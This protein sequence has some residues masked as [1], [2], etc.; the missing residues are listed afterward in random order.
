MNVVLLESSDEVARFADACGGPRVAT[1][2]VVVALSPQAQVELRRRGLTFADT[3]PYFDNDSHRRIL[4]T[5]E[6]WLAT[7]ER[8]L[9]LED[10]SGARVSYETEFQFYGRFFINYFL[11]AMEI[12]KSAVDR[13]GA[14]TITVCAER[15]GAGRHY[16]LRAADRPLASIAGRFA[17]ARGIACV[18]LDAPV[19]PRARSGR[20]RGPSPVRRLALK[21][22]AAGH[23]VRLRLCGSEIVLVTSLGYNM[24]RVVRLLKQRFPSVRCVLL[25]TT[26][27][28]PLRSAYRLAFPAPADALVPVDGTAREGRAG[29]LAANM[30]ATLATLR[31]SMA[32]W[33]R[34]FTVDGVSFIDVFESHITGGLFPYLRDLARRTAVLEGV[35]DTVRPRLVLSPHSIDTDAVLGELSTQRGIPSLSISHGTFVPPSTR[36]DEIEEYRLGRGLILTTYGYTAV[37]SPWAEQYMHHFRDKGGPAPIKTGSLVLAEIDARARRNARARLLPR[38]QDGRRVIIYATTLKGRAS[39]RFQ[40]HETLDEHLAGIRDM[41]AAVRAH[42]DAHLVIK[43]HPGGALTEQQV[44]DLVP[45]AIHDRISL[46]SKMPFADVLAAADLLV[47]YSSTCIE[48]AIHNGVPVLLYD[49]WARYR[50]LPAV[51]LNRDQAPSPSAVYYVSEPA[52]LNAALTWIVTHHGVGSLPLDTQRAHVYPPDARE[53]FFDFVARC[54]QPVASHAHRAPSTAVTR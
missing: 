35:L 32:E 7:A 25:P 2:F 14:N 3:L 5:S 15:A 29:W 6:E 53:G 4:L 54:L 43:L 12:L 48:E 37:Q 47:S 21:I 20:Q 13:H 16:M 42:A 1:P 30:D 28:S 18:E 23:R 31:A 27:P 8:A 19:I 10:G 11:W 38:D 17:R 40:I 39:L 51:S 49:R 24:D 52:A 46:A 22:F 26:D 50:H 34:R 41:V 33:R 36:A 9:K 44:R 45:E